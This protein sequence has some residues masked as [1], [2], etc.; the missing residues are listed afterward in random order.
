MIASLWSLTPVRRA[1]LAMAVLLPSTLVGCAKS[2]DEWLVDLHADDEYQRLLAVLAL[3]GHPP[4]G[5]IDGLV[6]ELIC[7][8]EDPQPEVSAAA[9]AALKQLVVQS[10]ESFARVAVRSDSVLYPGA[11]P[12][13]FVRSSAADLLVRCRAIDALLAGLQDRQGIDRALAANRLGQLGAA[14][15]RQLIDL[16]GATEDPDT[17]DLATMALG[18]ALSIDVDATRTLLAALPDEASRAIALRVLRNATHQDT[19]AQVDADWLAERLSMW[20]SP[21]PLGSLQAEVDLNLKAAEAV[22]LLVARL[23]TPDPRD[24]RAAAAFLL[25]LGAEAQRRAFYLLD[26]DAALHREVLKRLISGPH[27]ATAA[28]PHLLAMAAAA[29]PALARK[30]LIVIGSMP[31]EVM[32]TALPQLQR[33]AA[34]ATEGSVRHEAQETIAAIGTNSAAGKH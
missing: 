19:P 18:Q 32:D 22:P 31:A 23:S 9:K 20:L 3:G 24:S 2:A 34:M 25:K 21:D 5:A 10:P 11:P 14:A 8:T 12:P 15:G 28:L 29:D 16:I 17:R 13:I 6:A 7:A 27:Q 26:P 33:I 30:A 1:A 4:T